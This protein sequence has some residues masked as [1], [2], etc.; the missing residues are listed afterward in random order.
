MAPAGRINPT[1]TIKDMSTINKL[2]VLAV[3]TAF[4][5][6]ITSGLRAESPVN[7][8]AVSS[9]FH[10][11]RQGDNLTKLAQKYETTV[12]ELARINNLPDQ[13]LIITGERILVKVSQVPI[14][15]NEQK[16]GKAPAGAVQKETEDS[17]YLKIFIEKEPAD[18]DYLKIKELNKKLND[19]IQTAQYRQ[20]LEMTE[21]ILATVTKFKEK[22]AEVLEVLP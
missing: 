21:Q 16:S 22:L 19:N 5:T 2:K 20:A 18:P 7:S 1:P 6:C 9:T 4:L 15:A 13:N 3:T 12:T 14:S 17:G 8:I 10:L 11:I